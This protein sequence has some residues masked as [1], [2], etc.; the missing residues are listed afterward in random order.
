MSLP[1]GTFLSAMSYA[2][3]GVP[4]TSQGS[5][6]TVSEH[7]GIGYE[8][9]DGSV[10]FQ[11]SE[12]QNWSVA[13]PSQTV[14][15]PGQQ[16]ANPIL[17]GSDWVPL[18][19]PLGF[20]GGG[21]SDGQTFAQPSQIVAF[22]DQTSVSPWTYEPYDPETPIS[23]VRPYTFPEFDE[24][25]IPPDGTPGELIPPFPP[26]TDSPPLPT[27]IPSAAL[28]L[29]SALIALMVFARRRANAEPV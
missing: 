8:L 22:R 26:F 6:V 11:F 29:V 23:V 19:A 9:A 20:F 27:P 1:E 28:F 5:Y 7:H 21:G 14:P 16:V 10:M 13:H 2:S 25:T 3:G 24:E 15:P 4:K 18:I 17:A 12:C